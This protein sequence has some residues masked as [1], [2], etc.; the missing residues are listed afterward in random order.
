MS[1][2][3]LA[4]P[5]AP[6]P[7]IVGANGQ[8]VEAGTPVALFTPGLAR[9]GNILSPGALARVLNRNAEP[10]EPEQRTELEHEPRRGNS[11]V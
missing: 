3:R 1:V 9:G 7:V 6:T 2:A 10:P 4:P 8:S 5:H 11:E